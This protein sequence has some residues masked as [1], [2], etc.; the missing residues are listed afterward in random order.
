MLYSTAS[1]LLEASSTLQSAAEGVNQRAKVMN[2]WLIF[3]STL[4]C[5]DIF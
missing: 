5:P 1:C 3:S 2:G 4:Q